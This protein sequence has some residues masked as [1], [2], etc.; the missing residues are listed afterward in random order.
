MFST[1]VYRH[2]KVVFGKLKTL[3]KEKTV[4]TIGCANRLRFPSLNRAQT[5]A[6]RVFLRSTFNLSLSF[7]V[8]FKVKGSNYIAITLNDL[9][10]MARRTQEKKLCAALYA[11]CTVRQ[12]DLPYKSCTRPAQSFFS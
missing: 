3:R 12:S 8:I 5:G 11:T 1:I 10:P 2:R 9:F 6:E 7:A 4:F